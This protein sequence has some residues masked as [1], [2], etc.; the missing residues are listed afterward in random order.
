MLFFKRKHEGDFKDDLKH[1]HE[2]F[3]WKDGRKYE[4]GWRSW[5]QYGCTFVLKPIW[6]NNKRKY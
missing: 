1:G 2:V 3:V 4:G 6:I 5:K